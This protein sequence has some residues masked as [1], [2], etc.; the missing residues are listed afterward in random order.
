M[1]ICPDKIKT[2]DIPFSWSNSL[3]RV[4][5]ARDSETGLWHKAAGERSTTLIL[6]DDT[7]FPHPQAFAGELKKVQKKYNVKLETVDINVPKPQYRRVI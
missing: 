3:C 1:W 4:W 6:V 7:P 5:Y 2:R